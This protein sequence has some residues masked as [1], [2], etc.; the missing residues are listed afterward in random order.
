MVYWDGQTSYADVVKLADTLDLGSS[1]FGM[2]VQVLSSAPQKE[3]NQG[4]EKSERTINM[5]KICDVLRESTLFQYLD[6]ELYAAFCVKSELTMFW[7]GDVIVREGDIC[8][9][10]LFIVEGQAAIQKNSLSGEYTTL[11]LLKPG[12]VFGDDTLF[13]RRNRYMV[14]LE[15]VTNGKLI[16]VSKDELMNAI[17]KS[18]RLLNNVLWSL[19]DKVQTQARRI[20]LLSQRT[21]RSKISA[22]LVTLLQD[23]LEERGVTLEEHLKEVDK[24]MVELPISKEM[25]AKLLAMPRPSLSRELIAMERDGLITVSGRQIQLLNL[26][27]LEIPTES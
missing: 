26:K 20:N 5:K 11:E 16:S 18:P 2:Q 21:L 22:Y 25:V 24:P 10:I 23:K 7:K 17:S 1:T 3:N 6:Q 27:E 15:A 8:D 13:G 12:D 14:S 19:S 4:G 9:R